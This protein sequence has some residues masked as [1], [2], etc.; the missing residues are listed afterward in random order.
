MGNTRDGIV[1]HVAIL[2][3]DTP[4]VRYNDRV[5]VH[6]MGP[7]LAT[8]VPPE[9]ANEDQV[10]E[11]P[12]EWP[13][14]DEL[15]EVRA[16]VVAWLGDLDDDDR[17]GMKRW[18]RKVSE[19]FPE[20]MRPGFPRGAEGRQRAEFL[21]ECHYLAYPP[22]RVEK[23][24]SSGRDVA[25]WYSCAG[26]VVQCYESGPVDQL[27]ADWQRDDFPRVDKTTVEALFF[28]GRRSLGDELRRA[29]GLA[30]DEP[31]PIVMPGYVLHA[32]DRPDSRIRSQAYHPR[33]TDIRFP[34]GGG[35][36]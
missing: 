3:R 12:G 21:E 26:Y 23:D 20:T 5:Q 14:A 27:L 34:D 2:A 36:S 6:H 25:H 10:D 4:N 30:D 15:P 32:F 9:T 7:P 28:H 24:P 1:T 22:F 18:H 33:S 8:L 11:P 19:L 31:W 29:V 16:Q 35:T 17:E 13:L